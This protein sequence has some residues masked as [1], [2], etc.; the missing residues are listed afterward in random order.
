MDPPE[1]TPSIF[2][3]QVSS[4]NRVLRSLPPSLPL[5]PGCAFTVHPS[6]PGETQW[7]TGKGMVPPTPSIP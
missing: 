6:P 2:S 1:V 3:A 4:I 7:G 5:A